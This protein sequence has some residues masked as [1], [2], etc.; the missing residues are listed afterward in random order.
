MNNNMIYKRLKWYMKPPGWSLRVIQLWSALIRNYS[1][2]IQHCSLLFFT[3]NAL[4]SAEN[5]K[6]Q[7]SKAA[8]NQRW[9]SETRLIQS[10]KSCGTALVGRDFLWDNAE[11]SLIQVLPILV[12]ALQENL[13]INITLFGDRDL[14][15]FRL[16]LGFKRIF[17]NFWRKAYI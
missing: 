7:S 10:F 8:L 4:S 2:L 14:I 1:V 15:P 16:K 13:D 5:P 11:H 6:C 3:R 17:A 12:L 9:Y